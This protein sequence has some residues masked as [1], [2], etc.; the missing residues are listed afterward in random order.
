MAKDLIVTPDKIVDAVPA[1]EESEEINRIDLSLAFKM[2]FVDHPRKTFQ[3]IADVFNVSR[4]A[5]QERLSRFSAIIENNKDVNIYDQNRAQLLT[6]VEMDL[7]KDF[8]DK[9][10]R[11]KATLGNIAYAFRQVNEVVRLERNQPTQI[12]E[13]IDGDLR[14]LLDKIAPERMKSANVIDIES[15]KDAQIEA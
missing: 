5:V 6:A 1:A 2:R 14:L 9:D 15:G 10:K 12:T 8:L 13:N 11:E 7:I 4:Q 3:Q